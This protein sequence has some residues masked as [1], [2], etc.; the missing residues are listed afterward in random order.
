MNKVQPYVIEMEITPLKRA[1]TYNQGVQ[2]E[3]IDPKKLGRIQ[4]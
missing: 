1:D 2:C 3:L 4:E